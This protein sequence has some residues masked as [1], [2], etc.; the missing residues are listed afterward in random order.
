VVICLE[1]GANDLLIAFPHSAN[2]KFRSSADHHK[3]T[4]RSHCTTDVQPMHRSIRH[5]AVPSF[6]ILCGPFA[7]EQGSS[8]TIS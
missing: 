3:T 2:E 4:V 8:F 1:R 7:T 5:P 6:C